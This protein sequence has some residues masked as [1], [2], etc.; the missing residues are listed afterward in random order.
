MANECICPNLVGQIFRES[1]MGHN[2]GLQMVRVGDLMGLSFPKLADQGYTGI[3]QIPVGTLTTGITLTFATVDDGTSADDLGKVV[4]FGITPKRLVDAETTDADTG[5]AAET[6]V[7]VTLET[8]SQNITVNTVAIANAALDS[9]AVGNLLALRIRR[10]GS[11]SQDTCQGR[12]VVLAI[13]VV[14]T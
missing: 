6:T 4:R 13:G 3:I 7:D 9:V 2:A 1:S 8:T 5:A 14:G 12:V 11:A 10:I